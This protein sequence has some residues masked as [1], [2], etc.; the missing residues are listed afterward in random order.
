MREKTPDAALLPIPLILRG[1]IRCKYVCTY[2]STNHQLYCCSAVTGSPGSVCLLRVRLV[3]PDRQ[4]LR[5]EL[6]GLAHLI[7]LRV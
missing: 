4:R 5:T 1:T 7:P 6:R 3:A 2:D